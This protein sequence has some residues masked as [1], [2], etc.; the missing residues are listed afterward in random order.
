M[1]MLGRQDYDSFYRQEM[2]MRKIGSYTPFYFLTLITV[3]HENLMKAI[4][5]TE[6][7][8]KY[9]KSQ[10]TREAILLGPVA[11]PI[12]RINN[13]YRYQCLIKYKREPDLNSALKK[14]LE[15]YQPQFAKE[16]LTISIDVNPYMMM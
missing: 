5:T 12:P 7:I 13:R 10:I 9:I 11:S 6:K 8:T 14:V 16:G 4:S 2:M 3:S 1:N 15:H